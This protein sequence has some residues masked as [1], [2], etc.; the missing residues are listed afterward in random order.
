MHLSPFCAIRVLP[1]T[2]FI[3]LLVSG[4]ALFAQA[5]IPSSAARRDSDAVALLR[6]SLVK[7][8]VLA[9]PNRSTVST[10]SFLN[11]RTGAASPLTIKTLGTD[12]LRNEVGSDFVFIR[13]G[14]SGKSRYS[15]KDHNL[16]PHILA[17]KRPENLPALLIMSDLESPQV[18]CVMI[19]QESVNGV[20]ASHIRLS[21]LPQ[22]PQSAADVTAEEL[23][24]E[25]HVWID[26]QGL[27]VKARVFNFS[28]QVAENRSP[29]DLYYS[30][31]RQV[32]GF[33]VPFHVLREV[34]R[35]KDADITFTSI[36]LNASLSPADFQ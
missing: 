28:P 17:Y 35:Q 4:T 5:P 30:D 16:A 3:V 24:S 11:L 36:V 21:V 14:N 12:F 23:E 8:G 15:G 27:V 10:G 2:L 31:Y 25:T 32:D 22:N 26:A 1:K 19:G 34:D 7:M 9:T 13:N 18:N 29:V 6:Q 20:V 33:L